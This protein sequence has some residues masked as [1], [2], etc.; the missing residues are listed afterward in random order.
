MPL[1]CANAASHTIFPHILR[2]L[3]ARCRVSSCM[4]AGQPKGPA[5]GH[6]QP[7]EPASHGHDTTL[8]RRRSSGTGRGTGAGAR[9]EPPA[10][11][12]S[13]L[14]HRPAPP[15][16]SSA[17]AP[18]EQTR[19]PGTAGMDLPAARQII[20]LLTRPAP[21]TA[22]ADR[23]VRGPRGALRA[24]GAP[25]CACLLTWDTPAGPAG[26]GHPGRPLSVTARTAAA[27]GG[28]ARRIASLVMRL[29]RHD[30]RSARCR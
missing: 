27:C 23:A 24:L 2:Q 20:R 12:G 26:P 17:A 6:Q 19:V 5:H 30:T 10:R 13:R 28:R 16:G 8:T 14:A 21:V 1:T 3:P 11:P 7:S 4:A 9:A 29:P 15:D 25:T 18:G 22:R